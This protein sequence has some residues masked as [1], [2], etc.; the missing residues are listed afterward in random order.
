MLEIF[1]FFNPIGSVCLGTE[2][3]L[4]HQL[5]KFQQEVKVHFVPVLNLDI[6]EQFMQYEQLNVGN[7]A[8][9]NQLLRAAYNLAL[10]YKAAQYQGNKKARMLLLRLQKHA[11]L[12]QYQYDA[13]YVATMLTKC[14]LD[15]EMFYEDRQRTEVKM[16]FDSDQRIA[17]QMGVSQTP[18]LVIV[19]TDRKVDDGHAV[20]IEQ[21]TDP[22]LIP[23]LCDL[24]RTDPTH[25]FTEPSE[26]M[27]SH[28]RFF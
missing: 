7:L 25:F 5:D 12:V 23:R 11:P 28:F 18:S 20:L 10:D 22:D 8:K 24:I 15:Q 3:K 16:G 14:H 19:D 17:N 26:N 27:G 2:Q 13:A 9:R 1:L 21:I 4:L 6:I